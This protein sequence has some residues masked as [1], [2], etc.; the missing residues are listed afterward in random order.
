[1]LQIVQDC[2]CKMAE[3]LHIFTAT[4]CHLHAPNPHMQCSQNTLNAKNKDI[5]DSFFFYSINNW[6]HPIKCKQVLD[7][8]KS[9]SYKKQASQLLS[10]LFKQ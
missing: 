2:Q 10:G 6:M 9:P 1:M 7:N 4:C 5:L 3:K 8:W